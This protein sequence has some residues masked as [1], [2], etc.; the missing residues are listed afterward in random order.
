MIRVIGAYCDIQYRSSASRF[1]LPMPRLLRTSATEW[2]TPD[3][4]DSWTSII[5]K[6]IRGTV[7]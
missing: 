6:F 2:L 3:T 7:E 5:A 1:L 4:P